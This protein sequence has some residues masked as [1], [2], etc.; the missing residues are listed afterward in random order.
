MPE[1]TSPTPNDR[2]F[3]LGV[4]LCALGCLLILFA[5]AFSASPWEDVRVIAGMGH[6]DLTPDNV[7]RL[8]YFVVFDEASNMCR[9]KQR[10]W[11]SVMVGD[12]FLWICDGTGTPPAPRSQMIH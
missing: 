5:I 1:Q 7:T 11:N 9:V 2:M 10:I 8:G 4:F 3:Y 12:H 6:L